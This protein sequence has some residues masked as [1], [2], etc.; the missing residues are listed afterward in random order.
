MKQEEVAALTDIEEL[1]GPTNSRYISN[2][3]EKKTLDQEENLSVTESLVEMYDENSFQEEKFHVMDIPIKN[4]YFQPEPKPE[5]RIPMVKT[6]KIIKKKK[7]LDRSPVHERLYNHKLEG[8]QVSMKDI[9]KKVFVPKH[10]TH[11]N[12]SNQME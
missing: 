8:K 11:T 2:A 12:N 5:V 1:D 10:S 4:N 3:L 9:N 6:A 7:R